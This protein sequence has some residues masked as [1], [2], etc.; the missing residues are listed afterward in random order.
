MRSDFSFLQFLLPSGKGCAQRCTVSQVEL[1]IK[2]S[3]QT[4][5]NTLHMICRVTHSSSLACISGQLPMLKVVVLAQPSLCVHLYYFMTLF[6]RD[7][8]IYFSC[9][10]MLFREPEVFRESGKQTLFQILLQA[11]M[12]GFF[13]QA[14]TG[15]QNGGKYAFI[16]VLCTFKM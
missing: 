5:K 16:A 4:E 2:Y 8:I 9:S 6:L 11:T 12:P 10:N 14:S 3:G 15:I 13:L 7:P 1:E